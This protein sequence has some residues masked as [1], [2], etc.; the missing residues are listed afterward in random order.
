MESLSMIKVLTIGLKGLLCLIMFSIFGVAN[1][2]SYDDFFNAVKQDNARKVK[3][4]LINGFDANT[5][6]TKD[7]SGL[8]LAV[9]EPSPKAALVLIEWAKTDVNQLNKKGESALMLA[10]L[11]GNQ[12]IAEKLIKKGGDVNKTGWT[13]L[14]YAATGGWVPIVNLLLENSAYID[15]GSSNGTTPLMMAAMYGTSAA[16]N[17]LLQEGAD[18]AIKNQQGLT[19]LD[20]AQK[21]NRPDAIKAIATALKSKHPAGQW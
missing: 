4:L 15:A 1:A 17:F 2:G 14:H 21:G 8:H 9:L 12:Q 3:E 5:P 10:A 16:V 19:A 11:K 18:P 6:D 7:L 20:F 13:P